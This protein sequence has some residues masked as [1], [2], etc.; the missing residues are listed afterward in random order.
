MRRA[1][2]SAIRPQDFRKTVA[3][4][5]NPKTDDNGESDKPPMVGNQNMSAAFMIYN[6]MPNISTL[7][8]RRLDGLISP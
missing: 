7:R 8:F 1:A 5:G 3:T 2:A 6:A 4:D